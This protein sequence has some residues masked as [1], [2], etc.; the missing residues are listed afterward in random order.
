[1][2]KIIFLTFL[3]L[4]STLVKAQLSKVHYIPPL[5]GEYSFSFYN[6]A[7]LYV[8]TPSVESFTYAI[9]P[10][11]N[12]AAKITATIDA[13]SSNKHLLNLSQLTAAPYYSSETTTF[14][15]KGFRIEAPKE[16]YVSLRL[17]D[18]N[19][20]GSIVSK[21]LNALG[22]RFRVGG[23]ERMNNND[24]SFFSLMATEDN[25][26]VSFS[27]F[28]TSLSTISFDGTMPDSIQ[29]TNA[30]DS[31]LV[32]VQGVSVQEIIG[33]LISSDKD[34][35]VNCGSVLGS[36][37]NE[38]IDED[39]LTFYPNET[40]DYLNGSDIGIDQLVD[41]SQ[42]NATSYIFKK[43]DSYNSIENVL[44]I[45]DQPGITD[46][47]IND[48]FY[49]SLNS[50]E[51]LFIEGTVYNS[52]GV[53]YLSSSKNVYAFQG[54]GK[55]GESTNPAQQAHYYGANQG[56][57]FVPPLSCASTG[58]VE[59][60]AKI[61]EVHEVS[62]FV[63][64]FDGSVNVISSYDSSIT[65]NGISI[66]DSSIQSTKFDVPVQGVNE[67]QIHV[68]KNLEGDVSIKGSDELY[69]AYFNYNGNATSGS[70]YSGFLL[71]PKVTNELSATKLGSCIDPDSGS[72]VVITISNPDSYDQIKWMK[73]NDLTG[74]FDYL[75]AGTITDD[76]S[77]TPSETGIYRAET[78]I[79]CQNLIQ[80]TGEINI[81]TCPS[82]SDSD[83]IINNI[84]LDSDNDGILDELESNGDLSIDFTNPLSP[85]F[86]LVTSKGIP[87]DNNFT[88]NGVF[89]QTSS[90][91]TV[92]GSGTSFH[93]NVSASTENQSSYELNISE[94]SRIQF[95]YDPTQS[96]NQV[97]GEVFTVKTGDPNQ[98]ITLLDPE[99]QLLVDTS[100]NGDFIAINQQFTGTEISFRFNPNYSGT[101]PFSFHS[102]DL[103]NFA[104]EHFLENISDDSSFYG[105][106]S[107]VN[108][109]ADFDGDTIEN[110]VDSDSDNDGC[111]DASE[112][113]FDY[114]LTA[115]SLSFDDN[116][117]DE[118]GRVTYNGHTY[119][120]PSINPITGNYLF[121]ESGTA[122]EIN[123]EPVSA[124]IC[125]GETTTFSVNSVTPNA[126]FQWQI[127]GVSISDDSVYSGTNSSILTINTTDTSL[128]GSAITV[129]V[130]SPT[131]NCPTISNSGI[132]LTVS[133]IPEPP[134]VEEVYTFCFDTAP[135]I[136]DLMTLIGGN[137]KVF[138]TA[139]G[140]IAL[141]NSSIIN[142]GLTYHI[143][144]FNAEGCESLTRSETEAFVSN[145]V[146]STSSTNICFDESVTI[147]VS[148]VPQTAQD[149]ALLNPTFEMFLEDYDGSF[150]FLKKESMTWENAYNL[151]QSLGPGASMYVI[152]S[153]AEEEAVYNKLNQLGYAG[154]NNVN[155]THYNTHFWL[156][157]KQYPALNTNNTIDGGW[158]WLDGRPLDNSLA[159][160]SPGEPNDF[161]GSSNED[162]TEDYAQF[163]FYAEKTWNDMTDETPGNGVSWPIFEFTGSTEV[164]WGYIDPNSG[165]DIV[166]PDVET[167]DILVSPAQTTTYYYEVTTNGVVCR[168][169]ITVVVNPLPSL[170][171][172]DDLELCDDS[173]DGDDTNGFVQSFNLGQQAQN[174]LNGLN[175]HD[176]I[177]YTSSLDAE[178]NVNSIDKAVPFSNNSTQILYYRIK[179][180]LTDCFSDPQNI[181]SFNLVVTPLPP[182]INIDP[183]WV[184]D[185]DKDGDAVFNISDNTPRI[186][187]LLGGTV[188]Q[189]SISYHNSSIDADLGNNPIPDGEEHTGKNVF[190]RVFDNLSL[191][192]R[193]T[194]SFD[195]VV[196]DIP[197]I[198]NSVITFEEC[199][200]TDENP[201]DGKINL[202]LTTFESQMSVDYSNEVFTYYYDSGRSQAIINPE[203]FTNEDP[204]T[205]NA[206][207]NMIIYVEV[208]TVHPLASFPAS[209]CFET[210]E[211]QLTVG[212]S[213]IYI[214]RTTPPFK[215]SF[216]ACETEIE[217]PDGKTFFESSI[218]DSITTQILTDNPVLNDPITNS[219]KANIELSYYGSQQDAA[220]QINKIDTNVDYLNQYPVL[221]LNG[222]DWT[223]DIWVNIRD[224]ALNSC[225]GFYNIAQLNIERLPI[226]NPVTIDR[227]CDGDSPLDPDGMDGI[228]PFDTSTVNDQLLL[229]QTEVKV[230][231]VEEDGT[232]YLDTLPNPFFSNSQTIRALIENDPSSNTP[233]CYDETTIILIVDDAPDFYAIDPQE[234][235]DDSGDG[236]IDQ[237]A[238]FDTSLIEDTLLGGQ[239]GMNIFYYDALGNT[240]PSPLPNPFISETQ[241]ITVEI[242]NENNAN[243]IISGMI[244]FIVY[245]NPDFELDDQA[246][247]CLNDTPLNIGV[248]NSMGTYDYLWS[249]TDYNGILDPSFSANTSSVNLY[250]GGTYTITASIPTSGCS[251]TKSVFVAESEI[252]KLS[253]ADI[254]IND[255]TDSNNNS[256]VIDPTNLGVGDYEYAVFPGRFQ[257]IP[258]FENIRPGIKTVLVRDKN[259][260]GI[261]SIDVSVIGYHKFFSPN[262]DGINDYW[263]I[264]GV[265]ADFQ[266]LSNIYIFDRYGR[267]LSKVQTD[268]QG[269]DGTYKGDPLPADDYWFR[270]ELEDG[271]EFSGHFS[272][273]R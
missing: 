183:Y 108:Y 180:T 236:I 83:G 24:F 9:I 269:W 75:F 125:E 181:G 109:F 251:T 250:Q 256:I 205:G 254:S 101:I 145:P 213:T 171:P 154:V 231:F 25:T 99:N 248:Y 14:S 76:P 65:I 243:C 127:D 258:V 190:V 86:D 7:H 23:M 128:D 150:Y 229:G 60:I 151:I 206:V 188:G 132:N 27:D 216:E 53:M 36:F 42:T 179:N 30:G 264:L 265:S 228:F 215:M 217:N 174:I 37:S 166:I 16:I 121:L 136:G 149:F 233:S 4:I 164:V 97:S 38:V 270:V 208:Q 273:I 138:E 226:A 266:P 232:V 172:A 19:H 219:L 114:I 223:S 170:L 257:D 197:E 48:Q 85:V 111:E 165:S 186:L 41:L 117:V 8:S 6:S 12:E 168:D 176:V 13:S 124:I 143:A 51:H 224:T 104:F 118:M 156:G 93:S 81:G 10:I 90:G 194:D 221:D 91:A 103:S 262:Q 33:T 52:D 112:A 55:K 123:S 2:R 78:T 161:G 160:W 95:I 22:K 57:F 61:D 191:C 259:G 71:E 72:N 214:P 56:M 207:S 238:S 210:A 173:Q 77:L 155:D 84:D 268:S 82:D 39:E 212:S 139:T 110:A 193:F 89:S 11:G 58:D 133:S 59:S 152:N 3:L 122:A 74:N 242:I 28:S 153:S 26:N 202:N 17:K 147:S 218:F 253:A 142:H 44:I 220:T 87:V 245:E 246:V 175:D 47:T 5:P 234:L 32:L 198:L 209:G 260:C 178:E 105:T 203:N 148:G 263:N 96:H 252:A 35:V 222:V 64:L 182:N 92:T 227:A 131:Y 50:G 31:F 158:Q 66:D 130:S 196:A 98:T 106:L 169:E 21:G 45:A 67:Y 79:T 141:E 115:P 49:T 199:D 146:L 162:G 271:R 157:L 249:R 204:L 225:V 247:I 80:Y 240:L 167:Q 15:D 239:T 129:L 20:A 73:L 126:I 94:K 241:D 119:D 187:S 62:S 116:T 137:V 100:F 134:V 185:D 68:V 140:G 135:T 120:D 184:C 18:N 102:Y 201:S 195:L 144:S 200:E 189:Y 244:S 230:T 63:D 267:L 70:F 159:N 54:V 113:G 107:I 237:L 1:M 255:L 34:I 88:I 211:I 69:V 163:D 235:C 43:G 177:F 192:H 29:L 46:I 261:V 40:R 272:L